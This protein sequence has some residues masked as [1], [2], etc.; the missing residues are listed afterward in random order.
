MDILKVI[1]DLRNNLWARYG[2]PLAK[3]KKTQDDIHMTY[4]VGRLMEE[5]GH[6]HILPIAIKGDH[7]DRAYYSERAL[8]DAFLAGQLLAKADH[9][10][11]RKSILESVKE[12]M[13]YWIEN[14]KE[15]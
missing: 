3:Y 11:L 12:D 15:Y 2:N 8:H 4:Y 6:K 7:E 9:A 13:V 10:A 14:Y 1:D 5:L